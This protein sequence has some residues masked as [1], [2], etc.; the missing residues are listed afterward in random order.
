MPAGLGERLSQSLVG[1][2]LTLGCGRVGKYERQRDD[3]KG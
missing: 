3:Q 2:R 1:Y